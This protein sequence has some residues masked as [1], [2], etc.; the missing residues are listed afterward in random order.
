MAR[1]AS[2][3]APCSCASCTCD[4]DALCHFDVRSDKTLGHA[5]SLSQPLTQLPWALQINGD[6][7]A[8]LLESDRAL[9]LENEVA[10]PFFFGIAHA[11][12]GWA[13]SCL[14]RHDEGV[15]ELERALD[16]E[17]RASE[18]WA[19]MAAGLLAEVHMRQ[20]RHDTARALLDQMRSLTE[21]KPPC[22]F[23]PEFLRL[24]AQLLTSAGED[25]EARR[26]LHQAVATTQQQGSLAFA[27]RAAHALASSPSPDNRA[28]LTLLSAMCDR[29][30][31][32]TD[33]AYRRDAQSLV[34]ASKDGD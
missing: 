31:L 10:H 15:A 30:P 4:G 24:E 19:A 12:R 6:A 27:I 7:P 8:S 11:M 5:L 21:S 23:E 20:G 2:A 14:E 13:L 32:E 17:L 25:A 9:T 29:L 22:L 28:D 33:T 16:D 18:V 26:L 34:G 1:A 3:N